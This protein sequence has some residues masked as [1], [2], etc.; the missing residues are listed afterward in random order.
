[1]VTA[2]TPDTARC[3]QPVINQQTRLLILGSLPGTTSLAAGR[4][5]AHPRNQFWLLLQSLLQQPL[6]ALDYP[7]R[8]KRLLANGI[9]LWDVVAQAQRRGSLDSDIRHAEPNDL[10]ALLQAWPAVRAVAF[11]GQT[12]GRAARQLPANLPFAIL[13]SSSPAL[14]LPFA[15]KQQSWR[16]L[17]DPLL[18]PGQ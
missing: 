16:R 14:T 12:A 8:L 13:P 1:M 3:F 10:R 9:G 2:T 11:N 17:L 5:Y 7:D 4:Y 15:E 18:S 6:V